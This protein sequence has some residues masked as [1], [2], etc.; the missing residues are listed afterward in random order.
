MAITLLGGG[1]TEHANL[2]DLDEDDHTQYIYITRDGAGR[3]VY[4]YGLTV[5]ESPASGSLWLEADS[6]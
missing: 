6:A 4:Y 1:V 5:P 3:I 2:T